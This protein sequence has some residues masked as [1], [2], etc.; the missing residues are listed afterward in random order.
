MYICFLSR[1]TKYNVFFLG[2]KKS[3]L[4]HPRGQNWVC[5]IHFILQLRR[6][7]IG[8]KVLPFNLYLFDDLV[9]RGML[10]SCQGCI[11]IFFELSL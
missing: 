4:T 3:N 2:K 5:L 8:T 11:V 9:L 6:R 1:N 7:L 10:I